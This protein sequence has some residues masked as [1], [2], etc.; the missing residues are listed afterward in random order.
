MPVVRSN[1]VPIFAQE[2]LCISVRLCKWGL[3]F[4]FTKFFPYLIIAKQDHSDFFFSSQVRTAKDS[5]HLWERC[6]A[7]WKCH[8]EIYCSSPG[9]PTSSRKHQ[10]TFSSVIKQM[11]PCEIW[12]VWFFPGKEHGQHIL[13]K[14]SLWRGSQAEVNACVFP[15]KQTHC[16]F[17][18]EV[19]DTQR[20]GDS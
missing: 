16:P 6:L 5:W 13:L 7:P 12:F 1:R 4:T 10:L 15:P 14:H 17:V 3:S 8:S 20:V 2:G 11:F 9:M 18:F 19:L